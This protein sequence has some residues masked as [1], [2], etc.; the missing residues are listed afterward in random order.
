MSPEL[1]FGSTQNQIA[2]QALHAEKRELTKK[3][4]CLYGTIY[5]LVCTGF[6][7]L[8]TLITVTFKIF[9]RQYDSCC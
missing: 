7:H 5:T 1:L 2:Y 3:F 4:Q 9:E 8:H 6:C